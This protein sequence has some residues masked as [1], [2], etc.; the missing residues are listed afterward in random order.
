VT[1]DTHGLRKP[2]FVVGYRGI[3]LFFA[4]AVAQLYITS[5]DEMSVSILRYPAVAAAAAAVDS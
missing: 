3:R 2:H 1:T 5:S 4:I